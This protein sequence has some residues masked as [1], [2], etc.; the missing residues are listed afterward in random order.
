MEK[1]KKKKKKKKE[2]TEKEVERRDSETE[3][4]YYEET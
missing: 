3:C 2:G 4:I 1:K